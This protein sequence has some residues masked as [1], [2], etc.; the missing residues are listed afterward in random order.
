MICE[1]L[2]FP[3]G[4]TDLKKFYA[5]LSDKQLNSAC[6][7]VWKGLVK[8]GY[9]DES[10]IEWQVKNAI[11]QGIPIKNLLVIKL[12]QMM[13]QLVLEIGTN[14]QDANIVASGRRGTGASAA[15]RWFGDESER[16]YQAHVM[17]IVN[18]AIK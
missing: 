13:T 16:I 3:N 6:D 12:Y 14:I 9:D 15:P 5:K 11:E 10:H 18:K 4:W 8:E 2:Q 1:E 7:A 17:G